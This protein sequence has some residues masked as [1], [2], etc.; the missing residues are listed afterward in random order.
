MGQKDLD[1]R[2]CTLY[3]VELLYFYFEFTVHHQCYNT[4]MMIFNNFLSN[5]RKLIVIIFIVGFVFMT[6]YIQSI[7]KR[8]DPP[9]FNYIRVYFQFG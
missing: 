5:N 9:K 7:Y 3:E 6:V 8:T 4:N 1:S 2:E